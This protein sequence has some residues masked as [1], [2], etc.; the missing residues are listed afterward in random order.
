MNTEGQEISLDIEPMDDVD[1]VYISS[2][3]MKERIGKVDVKA[4]AIEILEW[5]QANVEQY[6]DNQ[7]NV[8]RLYLEVSDRVKMPQCSELKDLY[9]GVEPSLPDDSTLDHT[10]EHTKEEVEASQQAEVAILEMLDA[11]TAKIHEEMVLNAEGIEKLFKRLVFFY[12]MTGYSKLNGPIIQEMK[13]VVKINEFMF[14][15]QPMQLTVSQPVGKIVNGEVERTGE[16]RVVKQVECPAAF[17]VELELEVYPASQ[18][19]SLY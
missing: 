6:V 15:P 10:S 2:D 19:T 14:D 5:L 4:A 18:P 8:F 7:N 9:A 11:I 1:Q 13:G 17:G 16:K 3:E 12:E